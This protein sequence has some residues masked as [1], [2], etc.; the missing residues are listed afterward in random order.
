VV[1]QEQLAYLA[2]NPQALLSPEARDQLQAGFTP[3]GAQGAGLLEQLLD[4][5]RQA[6]S[7]AIGEVF[8]ISLVVVAAA[9]IATL[10]LRPAPTEPKAVGADQQETG[11]AREGPLRRG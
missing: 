9:W 11:A 6:L 8:L 4:A 3:L 2:E 7:S 5:L 10:F 1:P